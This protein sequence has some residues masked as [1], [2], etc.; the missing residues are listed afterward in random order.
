MFFIFLLINLGI[1]A[2]S[3][4]FIDGKIIEQP[5][6][7]S[8]LNIFRCLSTTTV[9][10]RLTICEFIEKVNEIGNYEIDPQ[11]YANNISKFTAGWNNSVYLGEYDS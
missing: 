4:Q 3:K 5:Y 6:Y 10:D 7:D 1:H 2:N 11:I 8:R 9:N